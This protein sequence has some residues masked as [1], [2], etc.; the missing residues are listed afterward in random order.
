[1]PKSVSQLEHR[2]IMNEPWSLGR[3]MKSRK[4]NPDTQNYL[5]Q[6]Q[7]LLL[8]FGV[9]QTAVLLLRGVTN[10]SYSASPFM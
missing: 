5:G 2:Y 3:E 8:M 1:M 10:P 7:N 6:Q 4:I 9:S